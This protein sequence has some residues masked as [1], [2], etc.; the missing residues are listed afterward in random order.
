MT[1][2]FTWDQASRLLPEVDRL[3]RRAVKARAQY[4]DAEMGISAWQMRIQTMGGVAVDRESFRH[5][6][7]TRTA[8]AQ[9]MRE[10]LQALTELGV[11]VKDLD[12]GLVDFPTLYRGEEVL[13]CWKLGEPSID[14][15]HGLED[16]FR[17]RQRIDSAFLS[18][19]EGG[20]EQ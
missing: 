1:R 5:L 18:Q 2:F 7:E 12:T 14:Y 17:G 3:L 6:Q 13:L 20:E 16:G 11:Q 15:W 19:H 10:W 8:A 9:N 4:G